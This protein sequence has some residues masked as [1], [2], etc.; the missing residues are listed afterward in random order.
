M[1]KILVVDDEPDVELLVRQKFRRQIRNGDMT[2]LFAGDGVQALQLLEDQPDIDMVLSDINMPRMDGLTLLGQLGEINPMIKAVIVSAYGDLKNIR[3]AMNRGAFDF[4]TKPIDFED[5]EITVDKTLR[6]LRL[7]R[8]A[9]SSRDQLVAIRRELDVAYRIQQSILPKRFPSTDRFE[10]CAGMTPAKDVGGDFYDFFELDDDR[11]GIAIAD[12][13]GK[14]IAAA[15]FMA[16]SRTVLR[17]NAAGGLAPGACLTRVNDLLAAEN[18]SEMFVTLFYGIVDLSTGRFVYANG[19]H[20]SPFRV[21]RDGAARPLEMTGGMALGIIDGMVYAEKEITLEPGDRMFLYTDGVTE[22]MDAAWSEFGEERL[23]GLL[24]GCAASCPRDIL[25]RVT[26]SVTQFAGTAPQAD[27]IT[28]F[29]LRFGPN[30]AV[31]AGDD[32]AARG[33]VEIR[34]ANRL[35]ELHRL[36]QAVTDF[37]AANHLDDR[38]VYRLN[39]ALDELVT[40]TISYGF[41]DDGEHE[42]VVK[43]TLEGNVLKAE[44]QDDG[45]AFDPMSAPSPD[46]DASV[47]ERKIGG[48][49][50]HFVRTLM[51]R[52]DYHRTGGTNRLVMSKAL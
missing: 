9:L 38:T 47:E 14:G 51:D 16:L 46:L 7:L 48:L 35:D 13:S 36:A 23:A 28:C 41:A 18:E 17:V 33:G 21:G 24:C 39:L 37:G 26:R 43:L 44:L 22:A 15:L 49:G 1:T 8:D 4:V 11:L 32:P 12:V 29:A 27:D 25:D 50:I 40:N 20:N 5:L 6:H 31:A 19:G 42:I 10:I 30:D 3:I 2:F 52:I 45:K 34:L